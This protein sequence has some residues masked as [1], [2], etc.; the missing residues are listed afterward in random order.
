M[1]IFIVAANGKYSKKVGEIQ[2]NDERKIA[3]GGHV[4]WPSF[5][6]LRVLRALRGS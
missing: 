5:E 4:V 2:E 3:F 6:L 1:S